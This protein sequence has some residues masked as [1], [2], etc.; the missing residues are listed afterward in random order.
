[1]TSSY[2]HIAIYMIHRHN[3]GHNPT[4][5]AVR[6]GFVVHVLQ[7]QCMS[8]SLLARWLI[9]RGMWPLRR[10]LCD[11]SEEELSWWERHHNGTH[12]RSLTDRQ[13]VSGADL[14]TQWWPGML[15]E[16][17]ITDSYLN[18]GN[19]ESKTTRNSC[20]ADPNQTTGYR[21]SS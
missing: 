8:C 1:M 4:A 2:I 21:R 13:Q 3:V 15:C 11:W 19:Q 10:C 17:H 18:E 7:S 12:V 6:L 5:E 16:V 20:H 14:V 9:T